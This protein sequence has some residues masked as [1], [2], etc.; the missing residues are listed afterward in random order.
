VIASPARV[1]PDL[2]SGSGGSLRRRRAVVAASLVGIASMAAV[3]LRQTGV[4][5]HL[6]DPPVPGFDS[7]KVNLSPTAFKFGVPDG[8]IALASL[9]ANL[10]LAALGGRRRADEQPWLP[11]LFA[12]KAAVDAAIAGWYFYQM[13]AK[14]KA[15]CGYCILGA[16][17]NFAVLALV[18]PEATRALRTVR[19]RTRSA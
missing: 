18:L 11:L 19:G 1:R 16:F 17:A 10:P 12:A 4:I 13:P 7:D 6:P 5:G 14:E 15:W 9:A 8:P 3:S 2:V